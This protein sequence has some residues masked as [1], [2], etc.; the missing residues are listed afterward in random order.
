MFPVGV[1]LAENRLA[2]IHNMILGKAGETSGKFIVRL[3]V[4]L[5]YDCCL[6]LTVSVL[7]L[8][9]V[10]QEID[11]DSYLKYCARFYYD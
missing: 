2:D 7:H 11:W 4:T 3:P 6:F 5:F 8:L 10:Y 9:S 1:R